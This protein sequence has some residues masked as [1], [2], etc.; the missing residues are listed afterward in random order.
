LGAAFDED[1]LTDSS[2]V[3][4]LELYPGD[5]YLTN[6]IEKRRSRFKQ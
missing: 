2:V 6:A 3:R 4:L 1:R 5:Q